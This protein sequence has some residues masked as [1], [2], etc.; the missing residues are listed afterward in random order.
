MV[1]LAG[2]R[3]RGAEVLD[4]NAL[5]PWFPCCC[6]LTCS[7]LPKHKLADSIY[8]LIGSVGV[9][10]PGLAYI[11]STGPVKADTH[12]AS[13]RE[14]KGESPGSHDDPG[15]NSPEEGEPKSDGDNDTEVN[16][17]PQGG[18]PGKKNPQPGQDVPPP[19]SDNSSMSENYEEKKQQHEDDKDTVSCPPPGAIETQ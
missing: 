9:T 3:D 12:G 1:S 17:A 6:A 5:R 11:L 2:V 8:R 14:A 10:V 4:Q 13:A 18:E 15:Q 16:K 7:V 19:P